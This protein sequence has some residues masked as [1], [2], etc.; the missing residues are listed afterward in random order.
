MKRQQAKSSNRR[1]SVKKVFLR[2]LQSHRKT[3]VSDSVVKK[4]SGTGDFLW[5]FRSTCL[6]SAILLKTKI[7]IYSKET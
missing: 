4:D 1:C 7:I 3:P 5:I 6:R 2:F